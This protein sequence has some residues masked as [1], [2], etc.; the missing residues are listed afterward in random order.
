[1]GLPWNLASNVRNGYRACR[2]DLG[3]WIRQR[4]SATGYSFMSMSVHKYSSPWMNSCTMNN[5]FKRR[6][7]AKNLSFELTT[8]GQ[9]LHSDVRERFRARPDLYR[10]TCHQYAGWRSQGRLDEKREPGSS[11][12]SSRSSLACVV[13]KNQRFERSSVQ[14]RTPAEDRFNNS[15]SW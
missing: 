3:K 1:M 10:A 15:F 14:L 12:H 2:E 5:V 7:A 8:G 11:R 13:V 6:L 9:V 4:S